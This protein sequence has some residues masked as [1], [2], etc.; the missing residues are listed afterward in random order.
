MAGDI[1]DSIDLDIVEQTVIEMLND[2]HSRG[3]ISQQLGLNVKPI[4]EE[5]VYK[6][7]LNPDATFKRKAIVSGKPEA[8][9]RKAIVLT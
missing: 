5:L 3:E 6:N 9:A 8:D 4:I 2:G 1:V 7:I